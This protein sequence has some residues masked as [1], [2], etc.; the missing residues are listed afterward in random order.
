MNTEQF[1]KEI[2]SAHL[3]WIEKVYEQTSGFKKANIRKLL[4]KLNNEL[5]EGF[6]PSDINSKLYITDSHNERFSNLSL[7][8]I[9]LA[10]KNSKIIS[11]VGK[12]VS[13]IKKKLENNP[14]RVEFHISSLAKN[15]NISEKEI[16]N[17][18]YYLSDIGLSFNKHHEAFLEEI[19]LRITSDTAFLKFLNYSGTEELIKKELKNV[20]RNIKQSRNKSVKKTHYEEQKKIMKGRVFIIM[21]INKDN[22]ENE[23]INNAIKE[24]CQKF[25]LKAVRADEIEHQDKITDKILHNIKYSEYLIADLTGERPNVYYEVGYAHA[26]NKKPILYRKKGTSLHFDLSIHN[27]PE[28][29][30]I[31]DLKKQLTKRLEAILGRKM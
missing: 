16:Q 15:T 5:P 19:S 18:L 12:I 31:T 7:L 13:Y 10:D 26:F 25:D 2:P 1:K 3:L 9:Y 21:Q 20:I 24:I 6:K 8:G 14:E 4:L 23:D 27:V 29:K 11:N 28:Y 30:N 17:Y 22:P